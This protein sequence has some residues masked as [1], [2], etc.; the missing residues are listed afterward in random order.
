MAF[1]VE[2]SKGVTYFL[3]TKEVALRNGQQGRVFFFS[4]NERPETSL[5]AVPD[6]YAV[7][8]S[9]NGLPVLKKEVK[10]AA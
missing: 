7:G 8:E 10:Q 9:R 2:N 4:K 6:G 1:S 5:D 3:N